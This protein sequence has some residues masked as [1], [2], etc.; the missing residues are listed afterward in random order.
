MMTNSTDE[1]DRNAEK[2]LAEEKLLTEAL[3]RG[4]PGIAY[5]LDESRPPDME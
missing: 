4:L 5:V 3:L 1:V 2:S